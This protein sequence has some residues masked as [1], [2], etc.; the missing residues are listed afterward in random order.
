M[1]DRASRVDC[2]R[3]SNPAARKPHL[4]PLTG[5]ALLVVGLVAA[6]ALIWPASLLAPGVEGFEVTKPFWP[7]LWIYAA[8]NLIGLT[9]MLLAPALLC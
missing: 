5:F 6:I 4:R 3:L 8:E 7:F 2:A 1:G 9:G